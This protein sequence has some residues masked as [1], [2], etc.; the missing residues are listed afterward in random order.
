MHEVVAKYKSPIEV[1]FCKRC[2]VSNQRPR[3]RFDGEGVC[4]ACRFAEKKKTIDWEE[5]EQKLLKLLAEHRRRDGS[6]DVIVPC[7]GGKDS[8]YVAHILRDKY[9]MHPLTVTWA[10]HIYTEI[11]WKNLQNFI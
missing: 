9:K 4:S 1:K 5:R 8:G 10:P 11:G 6:F 7:S 2:V 3:I